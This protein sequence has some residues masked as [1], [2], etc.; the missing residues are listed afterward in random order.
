[1]G[2]NV[3]FGTH[4]IAFHWPSRSD[5]RRYASR[6]ASV[7]AACHCP[8]L[9]S[10]EQTNTGW[11]R[12]LLGLLA[13]LLTGVPGTPITAAESRPRIVTFFGVTATPV[14]CLLC[15][16]KRSRALRGRNPT[17]NS[18]VKGAPRVHRASA[19]DSPPEAFFV[20]LD[21]LAIPPKIQPPPHRRRF[22]CRTHSNACN[23][24]MVDTHSCRPSF[25]PSHIV[26]FTGRSAQS[27]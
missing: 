24:H 8:W 17:R 2:N 16:V 5:A 15:L 19:G 14:L 27:Q 7:Q 22:R 23:A 6:L 4:H 11:R 18:Q 9:T 25:R 20:P 13:M 21:T 26:L 12:T 10:C 1:M 3:L